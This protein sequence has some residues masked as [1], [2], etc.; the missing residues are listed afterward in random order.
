MRDSALLGKRFIRVALL[1]VP[2]LGFTV[3][4]FTLEVT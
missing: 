1:R 3:P 2:L 4:G